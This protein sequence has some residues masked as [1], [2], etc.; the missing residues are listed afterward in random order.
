MSDS[1]LVDTNVFLRHFLGDI[2][3]HSARSTALLERAQ[4]GE[5]ALFPPSTV[6]VE[7]TFVLNRT[8]MI[9]RDLVATSLRDILN[10]QGLSTDHPG[11]L[12]AALDLW[13]E[14]SPLSFPDCFHLALARVLGMTRI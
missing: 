14:Q 3:D 2:L 1:V 13:A 9:S 8:M 12:I 6:F 10:I 4:D 7:L 11:A 5:V